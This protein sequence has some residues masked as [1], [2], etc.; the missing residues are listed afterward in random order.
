M[1]LKCFFSSVGHQRD[2]TDIRKW[3]T[4][5]H[6][7]GNGSGPEIAI[8]GPVLNRLHDVHFADVHIPFEIGERA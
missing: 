7:C 6:G 4:G 2:M 3:G 1:G 5:R 8:E